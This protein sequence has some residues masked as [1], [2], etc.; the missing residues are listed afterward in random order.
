MRLR[1]PAKLT[2]SLRVLGRRPDG[3]HEV[4]IEAIH[5]D[6]ADELEVAESPQTTLEVRSGAPWVNASAVPAGPENLLVRALD[7]VG[8]RAAVRLTKR[9]PVAGGLG[10]GSAD[11]AAILR[12][13]GFAPQAARTLGSDVAMCLQGGHVR[14]EGLGD[15]VT[16][17][18][19]LPAVVT[20]FIL[21]FGVSTAAVYAAWDALG[22]PRDEDELPNDLEAAAYA[23]EPRL[24]GLTDALARRT[25][26]R[27]RLA[28]S[29]STLVAWAPLGELGL[30]ASARGPDK[31]QAWT[32]EL[33]GTR[34]WAVEARSL[35]RDAMA[36]PGA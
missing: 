32:L 29:G 16:E 9:I 4:L 31:R 17:L 18:E 30:T 22:G 8:A 13:W 19:E 27:P 23:V 24:R 28:G 11:A 3:Y 36:R 5:L 25:G 14:A 26:V 7:L 12:A 1:A 6:L 34:L 35:P 21:P 15:V 33:E 20:L 2:R 10:G